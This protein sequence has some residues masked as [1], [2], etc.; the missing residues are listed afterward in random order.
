[1]EDVIRWTAV[2]TNRRRFLTRT[3]G[4]AFGLFSGLAVWRPP[5]AYAGTCTGPYG[6]GSCGTALCNSY[7]C[8]SCCG[9]NCSGVYG[10][11][12]NPGV[13]CWRSGDHTCCD[14]N[15]VCGVGCGVFCYC[16]WN[17]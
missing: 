16:H 4:A 6:G 8:G 17:F 7:P 3:L 13:Y 2:Q 15:C 12:T 10:F 9:F 11:C 14:C 1:M 5:L